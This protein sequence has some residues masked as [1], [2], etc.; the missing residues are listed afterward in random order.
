MKN[1]IIKYLVILL[2]V[3]SFVNIFLPYTN[4]N[5]EALKS[6]KTERE[7]SITEE[8]KQVWDDM[9]NP[10]MFKYAKIFHLLSEEYENVENLTSSAH[11]GSVISKVI[12]FFTIIIA[13]ISLILIIC[14]FNRRRIFVIIFDI[15]LFL[16]TRVYDLVMWKFTHD[17]KGYSMGVAYYMYFVIF[18][19]II[20]LAIVD[21][22]V[23][24]KKK[25]TVTENQ[26]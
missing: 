24:D 26:Q 19:G 3:L 12:E 8:Q 2:A 16:N 14:S 17:N 13:I 9:K 1:K 23:F 5:K 15:V 21:R 11:I 6:I 10:S 18:I 4:A 20:V 7:F 25:K 22:V